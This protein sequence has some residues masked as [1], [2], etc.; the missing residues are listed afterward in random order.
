MPQELTVLASPHQSGQLVQ[1][2]I[3]LGEDVQTHSVHSDQLFT[4]VQALVNS[5]LQLM[6]N[7][8]S[9]EAKKLR[10]K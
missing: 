1:V 9:L 7:Q 6:C 8:V 4:R 5:K 3:G 10:G 2:T